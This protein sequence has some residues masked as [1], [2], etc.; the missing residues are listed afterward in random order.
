[1]GNNNI[2]TPYKKPEDCANMF[3]LFSKATNEFIMR[4][5]DMF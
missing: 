4:Q 5:N 2:L 1:M 3:H